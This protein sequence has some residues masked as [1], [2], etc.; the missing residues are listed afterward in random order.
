MGVGWRA[1][2]G[3]AIAEYLGFGFQLGMNFQSDNGF[4]VIQN[5]NS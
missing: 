5:K 4:P 3:G 2:G 1:E